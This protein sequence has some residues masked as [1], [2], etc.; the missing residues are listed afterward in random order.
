MR[1][2]ALAVEGDGARFP[3]LATVAQWLEALELRAYVPG[4][5]ATPPAAE[6]FRR[7]LLGFTAAAVRHPCHALERSAP[8]PALGEP[9]PAARATAVGE[10][11]A[12]RRFA[13]TLKAPFVIVELTP[14]LHGAP[15]DARANASIDALLDRTCRSLHAVLADDLGIE[16][17]LTLPRERCE[18]LTP[19]FVE[20]IVADF[21]SRRRIA[22]WHDSG[23]AGAQAAQGGPPAGAWLDRLADRCVGLYATD[24][25]GAHSGLPAGAGEADLKTVLEALPRAAW[26]VVRAEP[27]P[28]PGPLLPA[29]RLLRGERG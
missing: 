1:R 7:D 19:T 2:L 24:C 29:V 16:V 20:H 18:W 9:V 8:P 10:L 22:W 28:G 3:P 27:F 14:P 13:A 11:Q 12:T 17:A 4:G 15:I 5:A 26:V 25:V 21:G 6:A 23:R